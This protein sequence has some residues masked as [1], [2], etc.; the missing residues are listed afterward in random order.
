[1][2]RGSRGYEVGWYK[3]PPPAASKL[4]RSRAAARGE[5]RAHDCQ[6]HELH[7]R[8]DRGR[9][10]LRIG[11]ELPPTLV[12]AGEFL[13]DVQAY[14]AAGVDII[15]LSSAPER[16]APGVEP[17]TLLAATAVVT[18]RARFG[19]TARV[20][21]PWPDALL[22]DVVATPSETTRGRAVAAIDT[23]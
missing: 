21:L 15:W 12:T 22:G 11:V 19:A 5:R 6:R 20:G 3:G 8:T 2:C 17:L 9:L 4:T 13:A 18:A 16:D 10:M 1:M 23:S 7:P 14:E